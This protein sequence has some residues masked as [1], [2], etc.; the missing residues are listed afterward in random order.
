[1]PPDT[2][3]IRWSWTF[4]ANHLL[5]YWDVS[6]NLV[7]WEF[8]GW[9]TNNFVLIEPT[10]HHQ[11]FVFYSLP[12]THSLRIGIGKPQPPDFF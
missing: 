5:A 3:L 12:R 8:G 11:F 6:T 4:P 9:T 2:K 7:N 1:M 10:N